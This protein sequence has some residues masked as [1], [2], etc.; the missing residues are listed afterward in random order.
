MREDLKYKKTAEILG[1][2]IVDPYIRD[3]PYSFRKN[4]KTI[5]Y[6]CKGWACAELNN[7]R[8]ENHRYYDLLLDALHKENKPNVLSKID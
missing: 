4:D 7:N 2:E 5:W 8:Y 6:C 3:N 1:W